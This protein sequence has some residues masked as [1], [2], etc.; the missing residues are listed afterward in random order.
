MSFIHV[1]GLRAGYGIDLDVNEGEAVAV[2][3]KNGAGKSTL[4]MSFF[5]ATTISGGSIEVGG[6][7]INELPP[8]MAAKRGVTVSP[9]GRMIL[10]HLTVA[11]NLQLGVA[12]GRKGHWTLDTVYKLFPVLLERKDKMGTALSGG[13]QQMLAVG[14]ALLGNPRV[15]LLDEPSEGLSPVLVDDLARVINEIRAAGTGVLMVEQH[16]NLVRRVSQ[17]FVVMA[18]GEIIDRGWTADI[19]SPKH[20]AALAF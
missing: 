17:R 11:E 14:R 4:I 12:S 19:G 16:L 18:K 5:G 8:Y 20:Q 1:K 10:G 6:S 15:L 13:Q 3:G 9:Q 7:V 2:V